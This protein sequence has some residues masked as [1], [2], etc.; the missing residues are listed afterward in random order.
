MTPLLSVTIVAVLPLAG[1]IEFV[2]RAHEYVETHRRLAAAIEQPLCA[3]PEEQTRQAGVLAAA[4]RDARPLATEG[5]IFTQPAALFFRARI[6]D[7][8]NRKGIDVAAYVAQDEGSGE[9]LELYVYGTLPW[10]TGD[11]RWRQVLRELPVLPAELEY[12][13]VG[14]H[15]ALVDTA[16]NLVV[17]VLRDALP[18][19]N[20]NAF[21]SRGVCDVHPEMPACWM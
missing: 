5:D 9:L 14:R 21:A 13:F 10:N 2:A 19:D 1:T 12:R 8:V 4:I 7:V 18:T 16:A 6:A 15:L 3:D 20:V 11:V 17:D